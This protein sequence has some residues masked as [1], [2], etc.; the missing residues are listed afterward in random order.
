MSNTR[1]PRCAARTRNGMLVLAPLALLVALG[2]A[3]SA[4]GV[5]ATTAQP[6]TTAA[7][8]QSISLTPIP[9]ATAGAALTVAPVRGA[10]TISLDK[11]HYRAGELALVTVTNGLA[12][13]IS[14]TDHKSGCS[15]VALEQQVNGSW[16]TVEPCHLQTPTLMVE[17]AKASVTDVKIG[18]PNIPAIYRVTLSYTGG[19]EGAGGPG[20]VVHSA[21]FTMS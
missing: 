1:L 6:G 3:L 15:I 17:L 9:S 7:S 5:S 11:T 16:Q 10:V 8:T 19:G 18:I 12:Q 14:T 4:C 13:N 20:G 21:E 2:L